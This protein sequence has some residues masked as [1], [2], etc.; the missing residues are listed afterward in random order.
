[1][2]RIELSHDDCSCRFLV[3]AGVVSSRFAVTRFT[4]FR[5]GMNFYTPLVKLSPGE[6]A[7]EL[8]YDAYPALPVFYEAP[9]LDLP[10]YFARRYCLA[11]SLLEGLEG[12]FS[13]EVGAC[14]PGMARFAG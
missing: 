6:F 13:I 5:A 7:L 10:V 3:V 12:L 9:M 4:P 2:L 14:F 8:S 11:S 1:M